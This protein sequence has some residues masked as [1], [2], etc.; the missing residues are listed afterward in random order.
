MP[1]VN[2]LFLPVE[3]IVTRTEYRGHTLKDLSVRKAAEGS[4]GM[5]GLS[6]APL[7]EQGRWADAVP[8]TVVWKDDPNATDPMERFKASLVHELMF[9][10]IVADTQIAQAFGV[11]GM[12]VWDAAKVILNAQNQTPETEGD[13]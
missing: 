6:L 12:T 13:E 3:V 11:V 10:A 8:H 5:V 2:D 4:P 9:T 1:E 7:D